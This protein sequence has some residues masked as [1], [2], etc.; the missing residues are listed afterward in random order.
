MTA[1]SITSP[2]VYVGTYG[3]YAEGSIEGAWLDL[4]DYADRDEFYA[5]C[6]A[7]HGPGEHEFM[8]QDWEGIPAGFIGESF[9]SPDV[10]DDWVELD[11]R[12]RQLLWIYRD[13][14]DETGDLDDAEEA[15]AGTYSDEE[16]WAAAFWE[17]TGLTNDIP[18]PL[19]QYIDY[20]AYARDCRLNGDMT[21]VEIGYREVWAFR[22]T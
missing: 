4:E 20:A 9:I 8:F 3:K 21:F 1:Y 5:A 17:E 18:V 15:Y 16:E 10:W 19:Q 13:H 12:E 11:A 2:R 6:Q 22:R 7:L 14:V